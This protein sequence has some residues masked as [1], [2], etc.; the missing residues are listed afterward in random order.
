VHVTRLGPAFLALATF[1]YGAGA[2]AGKKECASAYVEA[3]RL[4]RGGQPKKA[5][6]QLDVCAREDCLPAVRKD[7]I[8]WLDQVNGNIPS[9]VTQAKGPDGKDTVDVK[10]AIDGEPVAERLDVRAIELEP[11]AH[12]V[13]FE[14]A[15]QEPIEQEVLLRQGERNRV[16]AVTF[17]AKPGGDGASPPAR[18]TPAAPAAA[19]TADKPPSRLTPIVFGGI[20]VAALAGAG[21]FW[22]NAESNRSDLEN[23][24]C[25]P[26]C[27]GD[28]VA[29]IKRDR[30]VGDILL[31]VGV[32]A[33]GVA[34]Y[35]LV[36]QKP[37]RKAALEGV[38]L[39]F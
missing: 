12:K 30:I 18:A 3:Q 8:A 32:V 27:S 33:A 2:N 36:T 31:G 15:G 19:A 25:A 24:H 16:V 6:D 34:V 1:L 20:A 10:L 37:A 39:R 23:A 7:C 35:F 9:I 13:R 38:T 21:V 5:R 22:F 14:M 26:G 11:G 29:A 17:A 4:M 28:D